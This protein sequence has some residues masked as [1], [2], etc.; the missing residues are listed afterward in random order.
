M[1]TFIL[2]LHAEHYYFLLRITE[3]V[4]GDLDE[5]CPCDL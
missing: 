4:P 3:I 5:S 1:E 2:T